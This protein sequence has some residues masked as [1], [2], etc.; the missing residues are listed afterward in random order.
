MDYKDYQHTRNAVWKLLIDTG[1][2]VLPIPVI[3]LCTQAGI[4]V[5]YDA[6]LSGSR[7]SGYTTVAA[8]K[9]FILI[10]PEISAERKRFTI[11]HELGHIILGHVGR[12]QLVAREPDPKDNPV[13]QAA[14]V[15]ASRL[16]APA[17]V[18]W[19][20]RVKSPGEIARLCG[21]SLTAAEY[22]YERYQQLLRR[23]KFLTSELERQVYQQFT[24]FIRGHQQ[25]GDY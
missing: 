21:I 17:C 15:F 18:L 1:A 10:D 24:N 2:D 3:S 23:N 7:N 14:N 4:E 13:E 6:L 11:A 9:P 22:R 20:C 16:L 19:G 5:R 12:Y 8:D 25:Q